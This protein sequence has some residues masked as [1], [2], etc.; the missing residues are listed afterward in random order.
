MSKTIE[1]AGHAVISR[2]SPEPRALRGSMGFPAAA[3]GRRVEWPQQSE[4]IC[5][6]PCRAGKMTDAKCGRVAVRWE[7]T[8]LQADLTMGNLA[9]ALTLQSEEAA[10]IAELQSR[11]RGS[12]CV[13]DCALPST[14]LFA[15]GAHG[16]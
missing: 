12:I 14:H 7:D 9:S 1:G 11:L 13:A 4:S 2:M 15:A 16:V 10:L 6:R 8:E 3:F 5:D